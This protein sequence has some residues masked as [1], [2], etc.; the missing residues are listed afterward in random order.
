M[1][2]VS[3]IETMDHTSLSQVSAE[4]F[5]R[6]SIGTRR[7]LGSLLN[8]LRLERNVEL[9]IQNLPTPAL[10][11]MQPTTLKDSPYS[12]EESAQPLKMLTRGETLA[13]DTKRF[14]LKTGETISKPMNLLGKIFSEA[15]DGIDEAANHTSDSA[16]PESQRPHID[17]PYQPRVRPTSPRQRTPEPTSNDRPFGLFS[18]SGYKSSGNLVDRVRT[19]DISALQSSRVP[20]PMD[21]AKMQEQIDRAHEAAATASRET[22]LSI[23]P[24]IDAEIV[25]MVL[26]ATNGDVGSSIDK[27]LE[28]GVA[29]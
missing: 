13:E 21:F 17:T 22:L 25:D 11:K 28:I 8:A 6:Y 5:E 2:A 18:T 23:F 4:E 16:N 9:A 20:S 10:A 29:A 14:F 15:F 24:G 26:E 12:G 27:L 1:G 19:P 3:F 7:S